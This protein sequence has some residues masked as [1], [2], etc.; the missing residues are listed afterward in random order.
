ME[1]GRDVPI[2]G[3]LGSRDGPLW[4]THYGPPFGALRRGAHGRDVVVSVME[5]YPRL[6][7]GGN[8]GGGYT[9]NTPLQEGGPLW[10]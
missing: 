1:C 6:G 8:G 5:G 2:S 7:H 9:P 3:G 10:A 4:V